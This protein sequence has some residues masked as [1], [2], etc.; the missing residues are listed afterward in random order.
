M[1]VVLCVTDK[2]IEINRQNIKLLQRIVDARQ[3]NLKSRSELMSSIAKED[4][5]ASSQRNANLRKDSRKQ[6]ELA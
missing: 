2:K 3:V 1:S 4:Q 6:S 5:R